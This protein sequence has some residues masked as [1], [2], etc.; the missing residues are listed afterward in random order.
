MFLFL[1]L[2]Q[3][4]DIYEERDIL[5]H[6]IGRLLILNILLWKYLVIKILLKECISEWM[7]G[8]MNGWMDEWLMFFC[9]WFLFFL[10]GC[11]VS[12]IHVGTLPFRVKGYF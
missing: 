8:W 3:D 5:N 12:S 7:N 11:G 9:G 2:L 6:L 4:Y 10:V 1:F